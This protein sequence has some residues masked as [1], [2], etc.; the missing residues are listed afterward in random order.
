M[1]CNSTTQ[2]LNNV[3]TMRTRQRQETPGH[4][5]RLN[6][7][8]TQRR[9]NN[10][11]TASEVCG[12][13]QTRP[14]R[15]QGNDKKHQDM[16]ND[17]NNLTTQRHIDNADTTSEVCGLWQTRPTRHQGN[18]KKQDNETACENNDWATRR[19]QKYAEWAS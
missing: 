4:D 3:T 13:W 18:D 16:T 17:S 8:T 6:V 12:L 7:T 15:R 2:Q 14:T 11:D 19:A 9:N 10:A 5:Q 1:M